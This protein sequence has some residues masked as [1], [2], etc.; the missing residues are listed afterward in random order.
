MH[1]TVNPHLHTTM[2]GDMPTVELL[3]GVLHGVYAGG[4]PRSPG[5]QVASL[6]YTA[7]TEPVL[8]SQLV[9]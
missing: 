5:G 4:V 2:R 7:G 3:G 9:L 8:I 1:H 6:F